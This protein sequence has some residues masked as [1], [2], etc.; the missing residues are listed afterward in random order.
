MSAEGLRGRG[1][2]ASERLEI[3]GFPDNTWEYK[4]GKEEICL[5]VEMDDRNVVMPIRYINKITG[6][7]KG[8]GESKNDR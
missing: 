6:E 1:F 2:K 5:V 8:Y 3:S 7:T 4:K